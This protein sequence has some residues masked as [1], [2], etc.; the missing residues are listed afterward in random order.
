MSLRSYVTIYTHLHVCARN[1][2]I[3][4]DIKLG[5]LEQCLISYRRKKTV[6]FLE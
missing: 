3:V 4:P 2:E 1:S 5:Q 6:L